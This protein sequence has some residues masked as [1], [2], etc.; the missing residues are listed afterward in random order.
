MS[1]ISLAYQ[2]VARNLPLSLER[3]AD[4]P[5]VARET[6]YYLENIGS[7]K[8][9]DDLMKNDRLYR[10][11]MKAFG[12]GE[13]T[14]AKGLVRKVLEGGIDDRLSYANRLSDPRYK[15][16]ASAFNF[17]RYG[18]L[19]TTF[20]AVKQGAVDKYVRQTLEED[21]GAQNES[22]RL[23]LYFQRKA[24][25]ITN[26]MQLLADRALMKV[27]QTALQIPPE[28]S[29]SPLERQVAL[30]EKRLNVADLKDPKKL[31]KFLARFTGLAELTAA[32]AQS[33]PVVM[34]MGG[35]A[36]AGIGMDLLFSI[37]SLRLGGR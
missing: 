24:P 23:A 30:I 33:S 29:S 20:T 37:Q 26:T 35:Q 25:S 14:Y 11:A 8:S 2:T 9:I 18:E 16:L 7:V 34:L 22:V 31:E 32:P 3:K 10:F 17:V 36:P 21:V 4:E 27:V 15:E 12:L 19:T 6:K 28:T 13:M 5:Q 1:T